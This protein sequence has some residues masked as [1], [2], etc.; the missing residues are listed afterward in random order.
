MNKD[1]NKFAQSDAHW[2]Y[3][4]ARFAFV[5][6]RDGRRD[7]ISRNNNKCK[8]VVVAEQ[9]ESKSSSWWWLFCCGCFPQQCDKGVSEQSYSH[10]FCDKHLKFAEPT[11]N[12]EEQYYICQCSGCRDPTFSTYDADFFSKNIANGHCAQCKCNLCVCDMYFLN[13][14]YAEPIW[15][16]HATNCHRCRLCLDRSHYEPYNSGFPALSDEEKKELARISL[17]SNSEFL[18]LFLRKNVEFFQQFFSSW[19]K[20]TDAERLNGMEF[21]ECIVLRDAIPR[22]EK[23]FRLMFSAQVSIPFVCW[24]PSISSFSFPDQEFIKIDQKP[25]ASKF[26]D[27]MT[28]CDLLEMHHD[29]IPDELKIQKPNSPSAVVNLSQVMLQ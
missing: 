2:N 9:E 6:R 7:S 15:P 3:D 20:C 27:V 10:R 25:L 24:H 17:D 4:P 1:L 16:S 19:K 8:F 23:L 14:G 12:Y 21:N 18:T 22:H 28:C 26:L 5:K 29:C 13:F 11:R